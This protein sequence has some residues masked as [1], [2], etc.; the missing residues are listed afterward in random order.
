[1]VLIGLLKKQFFENLKTEKFPSHVIISR[2]RDLLNIQ[3]IDCNF[4]LTRV[5]LIPRS[6]DLSNLETL[7]KLTFLFLN[8]VYFNNI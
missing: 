5:N 8:T 3:K 1:M 2:K 6:I 7:S 4:P